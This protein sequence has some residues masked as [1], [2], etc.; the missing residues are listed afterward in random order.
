MASSRNM[1][2]SAFSILPLALFSVTPPVPA[3]HGDEC[4]HVLD[5]NK[6]R[7]YLFDMCE[8]AKQGDAG[9]MYWLGLAYIEGVVLNDYDKGVSWLKKAAYAGNKEASRLYEFISSA[10]VGPGC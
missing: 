5:E 2:R 7:D 3:S 6:H 9:A 1:Y 10:E 8:S 4:F